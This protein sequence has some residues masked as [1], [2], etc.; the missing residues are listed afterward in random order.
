MAMNEDTYGTFET[1][2]PD[3]KI[4]RYMAAWKFRSLVQDGLCFTRLDKLGDTFE[5]PTPTANIQQRKDN[6][7]RGIT[8]DGWDLVKRKDIS[9]E[10]L[11]H[12]E[13]L[14]NENLRL[15]TYVSCWTIGKIESYPMWECYTDK[16]KAAVAIVSTV[17]RLGTRIREGNSS[18]YLGEVKYINFDIVE[19]REMPDFHLHYALQKRI[20][21]K[22][23]RELRA[24][25]G[26]T[27]KWSVEQVEPHEQPAHK[28]CRVDVEELVLAII[29]SPYADSEAHEE[30]KNIIRE[31][32]LRETLLGPSSLSG[33][34]QF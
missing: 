12:D 1:P 15:C 10:A 24:V 4:M 5:G 28:F 14:R 30:V 21:Y 22:D 2:P 7:R 11:I 27:S 20:E 31:A 9:D 6:H 32:N 26:P 19:R 25:M 13:S 8:G 33:K 3:T 34:P 29:M 18:V 16:S 23:E 17:E